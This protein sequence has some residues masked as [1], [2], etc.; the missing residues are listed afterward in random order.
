MRIKS[1]DISKLTISQRQ[2]SCQLITFGILK[3]EMVSPVKVNF[4]EGSLLID[5]KQDLGVISAE[6][7]AS[8]I[9]KIEI[10]V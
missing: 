5:Y 6:G 3:K 8:F 7:S 10:E 2:M 4:Q 9:E 1:T